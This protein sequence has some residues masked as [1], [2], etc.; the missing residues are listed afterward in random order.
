VKICVNRAG[1]ITISGFR[2]GTRPDEECAGR[3]W[4]ERDA[5][6]LKYIWHVTIIFYSFFSR[7]FFLKK[8]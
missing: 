7:F 4:E 8:V 5:Y 1:T 2:D 3:R 6:H